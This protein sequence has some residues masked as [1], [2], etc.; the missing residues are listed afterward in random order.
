VLTKDEITA[1]AGERNRLVEVE[2]FVDGAAIDPVFYDRTYYLGARDEEGPYRLLRDAL[3]R[4][5]R[6]GIGRWTFHNREY[7]VAVRALDGILAL[8]T[9]RFADELVDPGELD[10]PDPAKV[11]GDREVEMAGAL[12]ESLHGDFDPERFSDTYRE[13]ILDF[14]ERKRRG[15]APEPEPAPEPERSD[16]LL[17]ALQASL[18]AGK[19][20]KGGKG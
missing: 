7:L 2:H 17:A 20:G 19:S 4:T 3:A 13:R 10:V 5:G 9:M 18:D 15:E 1:A 8:H 14:L 11:P 16:D 6:A 12:V